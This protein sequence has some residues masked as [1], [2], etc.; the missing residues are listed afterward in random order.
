MK[1]FKPRQKDVN[2]EHWCDCYSIAI[3]VVEIDFNGDTI[4]QFFCQDHLD[5]FTKEAQN[6]KM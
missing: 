5:E 2:C 6:E 3:W 4:Y 1:I